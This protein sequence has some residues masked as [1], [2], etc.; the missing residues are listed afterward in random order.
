MER[1]GDMMTD[2]YHK[3]ELRLEWK[4][5]PTHVSKDWEFD[6]SDDQG[7]HATNLLMNTY[8]LQNKHHLWKIRVT[9]TTLK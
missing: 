6:W 9:T 5:E 2:S 4:E 8:F 1:K 3:M 7:K